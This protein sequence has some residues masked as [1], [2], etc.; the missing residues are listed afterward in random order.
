ME[1][2]S[3]LVLCAIA[4]F[5]WRIADQM[6]DVLFRLS[7]MQKDISAMRRQDDSADERH[8]GFV[9]NVCS[10]SLNTTELLA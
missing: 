3:F 10:L 4:F 1:F 5:L 8:S 2:L 7:E 9:F 6:P